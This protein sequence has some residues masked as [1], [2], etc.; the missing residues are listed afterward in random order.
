MTSLKESLTK[1]LESSLAKWKAE[2]DEVTAKAK[3]EEADAEARRARADLEK[4]VWSRVEQLKSKVEDAERRLAELRKSTEE[5]AGRI[6]DE[7]L[8]LV[9]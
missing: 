8:R 7:V 3:A 4:E 9:A 1:Q 6:R 5:E 2:I